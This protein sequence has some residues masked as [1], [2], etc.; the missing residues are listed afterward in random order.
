MAAFNGGFK[1]ADGHYGMMADGKVYVPP[2]PGVAT[3]AVTRGGQVIL[4]AWG[5]DPRLTSSNTDLIAWRQNAALLLDN[6]AINPLTTDGAAW[7]GTVL[8]STYTWR[9]GIGVTDHGTLIYAGGNSISA[10]TLGK[11]LRM[12]GAVYAMQ[13][14]I[15]PYWVRAFLYQRT[16]SGARQITKLDTGMQG[17][18]KEYLDGTT[19]DFF[20]LTRAG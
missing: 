8:N 6:G 20:Y 12:A 11:S 13:T 10:E 14:D 9:S 2:Q 1:Y 3:I 16:A 7:G 5:V 15:N 17:S 19:R 4:G 18:G